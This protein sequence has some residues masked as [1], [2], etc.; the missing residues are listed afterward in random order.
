MHSHSMNSVLATMLDPD[1]SEFKVTHIEMI[2]VGGCCMVLCA[3][4]S[5]LNAHHCVGPA[6]L[7]P[8]CPAALLRQLVHCAVASPPV[9]QS[10]PTRP[11]CRSRS[12]SCTASRVQALHHQAGI[13][14]ASSATADS[15]PG[16]CAP[17]QGI[18]GHGFYGNCVVPIIENTARECELTDRLRQA[19]K[20]Y[21]E[22][23]AVLV[24]RHGEQRRAPDKP[25]H[26]HALACTP[27]PSL[28]AA[29]RMLLP[30]LAAASHLSW[31]TC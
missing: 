11:T 29:R 20:D 3:Q 6:A 30:A 4:P 17:L 23:K 2:K 18:E 15:L 12:S 9:S 10:G 8:C 27:A 19:I 26:W 16:T 28:P 14:A 13:P 7:L 22:A 31:P 1:S 24:R 21:P 5:A 25:H